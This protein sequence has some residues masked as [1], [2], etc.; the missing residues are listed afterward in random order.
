[1]QDGEV[2]VVARGFDEARE[3]GLRDPLQRLLALVGA[4]ELEGRDP[5]AVA[6]LLGEVDDE[7]LV[8]E[9]VEEVVGR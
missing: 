7:G 8:L 2:G 6:A 4:P 3:H 5:E 9:D 1:V